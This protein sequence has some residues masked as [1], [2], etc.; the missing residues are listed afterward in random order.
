[1]LI[2]V[3][4]LS[5]AQMASKKRAL[6][7]DVRGCLPLMMASRN[8]KSFPAL[9]SSVF[10]RQKRMKIERKRLSA[11]QTQPDMD[12]YKI[13]LQFRLM[14]Q[15]SLDSHSSHISHWNHRRSGTCSFRISEMEQNIAEYMNS[16]VKDGHNSQRTSCASK[17]QPSSEC[18]G[19]HCLRLDTSCPK[20]EHFVHSF[21]TLH[22]C[23]NLSSYCLSF[24]ATPIAGFLKT[25]RTRADTMC[26]YFFKRCKVAICAVL[27][28]SQTEPRPISQR[29]K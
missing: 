19:G 29:Q 23:L 7:L 25:S 15:T 3:A 18:E 5:W 1:M 9:S 12:P 11:G 10:M 27:Q 2:Q 26:V 14:Q 24:D 4:A 28:C 22:C 6:D 21:I 17:L 13:F 16:G 8:L 20:T